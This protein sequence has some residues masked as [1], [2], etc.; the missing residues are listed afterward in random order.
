[1]LKPIVLTAAAIA[2]SACTTIRNP[3]RGDG[4]VRINPASLAADPARWDGR[5]VKIVG[6]LVWEFESAGLYQS[7]G[8]YCRGGE[9][10]AIYVNWNDWS[11]VSRADSRRRVIVRGVFR[12][13]PGVALE[14]M[15]STGRPGTTTPKLFRSPVTIPVPLRR[16][17]FS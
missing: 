3:E 7:Y 4:I 14:A 15:T 2:L 13:V 6:L 9:K 17:P 12:N 8:A 11:G 16:F 10:A 5:Q 1:M